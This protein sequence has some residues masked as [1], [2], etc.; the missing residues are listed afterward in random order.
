MYGV[1][2]GTK[3]ILTFRALGNTSSLR[4]LFFE[5]L[6]V[7]FVASIP[8]LRVVASLVSSYCFLGR[9]VMYG[10]IYCTDF[11]YLTYT[12]TLSAWFLVALKLCS[13]LTCCSLSLFPSYSVSLFPCYQVT[14]LPCYLVTLLPCYL[15]TLLPCYSVTLLPCYLVTLLPCYS[16]TLLPCYSVT[17]LP[18]YSVTLLLCYPVV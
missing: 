5:P 1:R 11:T 10:D 2:S 14:L 4:K 3:S 18:C 9:Y 16:V 8:F 13:L 17:L 15:V 6:S 7:V 12:F